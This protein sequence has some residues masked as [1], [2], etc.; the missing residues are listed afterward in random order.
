MLDTVEKIRALAKEA[1]S[2]GDADWQDNRQLLDLY[3]SMLEN[4]PPKGEM[5]SWQKKAG[6]ATLAAAK[7]ALVFGM[8]TLFTIAYLH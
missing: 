4:K 6:R 5:A 3:I 7:V 8:I 2:G 1:R